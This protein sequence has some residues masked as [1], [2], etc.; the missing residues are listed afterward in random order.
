VTVNSS[1]NPISSTA[2][3][4]LFTN[5]HTAYDFD[6]TEITDERL[7]QI[8]ELT[9]MAPTAMNSQPLRV[10]YVKSPEAKA[11]LLPLIAESNRKKSES[12]SVVA[13]LSADL[14][15]HEHFD[16][17]QPQNPNAK[18][19][20]SD[21]IKREQFARFNASLQAGYFI[22]AVRAVG[23]DAGPMAGV[24]IDGINEEFLSGTNQKTLFVVNIGQVSKDG[25]FP[26]NG[27][28]T[29]EQAVKVL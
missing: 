25:N 3:E 11:R 24:D 16:I 27:R 7:M 5:A 6:K 10:T 12:A 26:R 17:L 28:L 20:F 14:N 22:L 18:K 23:L 21:P 2:I 19:N 8:Y 15:F 29:Y 13:I 4:T 1:S 9:K